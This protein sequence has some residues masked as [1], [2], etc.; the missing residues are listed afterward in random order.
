MNQSALDVTDSHKEITIKPKKRTCLAPCRRQLDRG[1]K[2]ETRG[3]GAV[4]KESLSCL[5]FRSQ[6]WHNS[7]FK[8]IA[9]DATFSH[10]RCRCCVFAVALCLIE[11]AEQHFEI[12]LQC[13]IFYDC[14][15]FIGYDLL[16]FVVIGRFICTLSGLVCN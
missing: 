16:F 12:V 1:A 4:A 5:F 9:F 14:N 7:Q 8:R 11:C 2:L 3:E 15:L 10:F 13:L 6:K